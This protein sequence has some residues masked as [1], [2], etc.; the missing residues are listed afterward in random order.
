MRTLH[1]PDRFDSVEQ[2]EDVMSQPS[3]ALIDDLQAVDGDILVLGAGGKMGPTVARLAK[4]AVP[5]KRCQTAI[6]L[7][8]KRRP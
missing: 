1:L 3:P 8:C 2:L 6:L 7:R 4:R 5:D